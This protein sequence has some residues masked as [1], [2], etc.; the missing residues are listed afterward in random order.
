MYAFMKR[1]QVCMYVYYY[2]I[3]FNYVHYECARVHVCVYVGLYLST[4]VFK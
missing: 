4:Y 3:M 2:L 1:A